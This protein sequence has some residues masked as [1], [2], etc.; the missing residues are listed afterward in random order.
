MFINSIGSKGTSLLSSLFN[1][2][3]KMWYDALEK[4]KSYRAVSSWGSGLLRR[5]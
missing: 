2:S 4:D 1:H 3:T 5:S